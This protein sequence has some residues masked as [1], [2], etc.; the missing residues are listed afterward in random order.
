MNK[1][2]AITDAPAIGHIDSASVRRAK[3]GVAKHSDRA[4]HSAERIKP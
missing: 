4:S 1:F 2:A 3:N